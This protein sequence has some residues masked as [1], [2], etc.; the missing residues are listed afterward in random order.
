LVNYDLPLFIDPFLL[1]CYQ[2][3][4]EWY[5]AIAQYRNQFVSGLNYL[6]ANVYF[7][8]I[9]KDGEIKSERELGFLTKKQKFSTAI[10]IDGN[11][12][13]NTKLSLIFSIKLHNFKAVAIVCAPFIDNP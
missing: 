2:E 6:F 12:R 3:Y 4:N 7:N 8:N 5:L 10:K 1:F 9:E 13:K 11:K